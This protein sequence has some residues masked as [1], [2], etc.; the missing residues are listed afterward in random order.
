M[1]HLKVDR[2]ASRWLTRLGVLFAKC[3]RS[4]KPRDQSGLA[5][6]ARLL[7]DLLAEKTRDLPRMAQIAASE[8][9]GKTLDILIGQL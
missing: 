7:A 8:K 5:A 1:A 3:R 9:M 2:Q 4:K 6:F